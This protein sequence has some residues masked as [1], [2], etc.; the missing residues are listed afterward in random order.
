MRVQSATTT[1][2]WTIRK[3]AEPNR[4]PVTKTTVKELAKNKSLRRVAEIAQ[5]Y[6]K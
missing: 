2:G 3:I 1:G 4:G 5:K 6:A